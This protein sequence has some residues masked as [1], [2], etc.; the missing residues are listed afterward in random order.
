MGGIL[1]ISGLLLVLLV[2]SGIMTAIGFIL[3]KKA[4]WIPSLVLLI[5]ALIGS[6]ALLILIGAM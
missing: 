3:K 1:G 4:I 6:G 5:L 2:A